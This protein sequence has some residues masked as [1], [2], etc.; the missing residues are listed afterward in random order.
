M[1]KIVTEGIKFSQD[2]KFV[3]II[4]AHARETPNKWIEKTKSIENRLI[5]GT[6][7]QIART[8]LTENVPLKIKDFIIT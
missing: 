3:A 1:I 2:I 7:T 6:T 8:I 4:K 5:F